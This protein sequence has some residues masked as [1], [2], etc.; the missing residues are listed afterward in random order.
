MENR[1]VVTKREGEGLGGN[2]SLVLVDADYAFVKDKQRDSA[3][4]PKEL[5]LITCYGR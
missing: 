3:V 1:L 5:Y 2:G 4:Q